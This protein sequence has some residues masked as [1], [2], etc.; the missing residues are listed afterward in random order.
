MKPD[1]PDHGEDSL[2]TLLSTPY[3]GADGSITPPIVQSSL[4]AFDSYDAFE[5][6][7]AGRS[8]QSIYSRVQNP[9]VRA[10]ENL[11]ASA[12]KTE[13]AIGFASGMAAISSTVMAF[14]KPGQKIVCIENVY[15]DSYRL[16]ERMLRPIGIE[17]EY[18]SPAR[19]LDD[20]SIL[21]GAAVVYLE[22]PNSIK[23]ETV[24]LRRTA[25]EAGKR[26]AITIIDNSWATP[27]FQR[28]SELGI[29]LVL[30]SASKYISGHSDTVAGVVAG[31]KAH[32]DVIRD[33]TQ[34]LLGGKLA[35]FEA[36]LLV[37]GLRTLVPR[38]KTHQASANTFIDRLAGLD[39]VHR[40]NAPGPNSAAGLHG[41]SGL[42]SIELDPAV[43]IRAFCNVLRLFKLGVSW[44]GFESLVLPAK[45]GI[46]QAGEH[47]SMRTFKVPENLVRISIGLEETD[48][49][50]ADFEKALTKAT[51]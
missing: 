29:D 11:M 31:S 10:F 12:E 38:M 39:T 24:D 16:F 9:T 22:S 5:D 36:W 33:L 8:D 27:V 2:A 51:A 15:P 25:D 34:P 42:F 1:T 14:A 44:G 35:P 26:G 3:E 4:F 46:A 50:W 20:P 23:F 13:D 17:T 41:R 28:P 48:D 45:V 49:L 47:N 32:L 21:D 30:H 19:M 40:I 37:R 7:M 18:V 43:D 6:R